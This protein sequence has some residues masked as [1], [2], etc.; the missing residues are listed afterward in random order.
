[1][2]PDYFIAGVAEAPVCLAESLAQGAPRHAPDHTRR[3]AS[4]LPIVWQDGVP[5]EPQV[6]VGRR[7][8]LAVKRV[9]DIVVASV[10]LIAIGPLLAFTALA[11]RLTSEGPILF[12]QTR[13]GYLG[14]PFTIY[15]F[16]SMYS[17][18]CDAPGSVQAMP[19]DERVTP[20]GRFI[21][22]ISIDELPQLFN[23]LI[24]DMS[25][26]GPRPYVSEMRAAGGL[27]SE[28]VPYFSFRHS[29]TPG[30][31]GWAQANGYRGPTTS[32]DRSVRRVDHDVAYIQN[33]S[34]WLD[35]RTVLMTVW[36]ELTGGS[37]V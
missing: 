31:T 26:V 20:V 21:R 29:M 19:G 30:L 1:L 5:V 37:G 28:I 16:R 22:K 3:D 34:L 25:L 6:T 23:V 2:E 27:Y 13:V 15:K 7:A 9:V 35:L 10:A 12:R 17:D 36:R 33:F 11:I 14:R 32:Y 8:A 24:G 4:G 18:R